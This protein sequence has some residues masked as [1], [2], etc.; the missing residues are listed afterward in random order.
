MAHHIADLMR[1]AKNVTGAERNI[2]ERQC[3][4]TIFKLWSHR[5]SFQSGRRPL[6]SFE[7]IFQML[8]KMFDERRQFY[9]SELST[10]D[11]EWLKLAEATDDVA[12]KIIRFALT[13]ASEQAS[14]QEKDWLRLAS[15]LNIQ[16]DLEVNLIKRLLQEGQSQGEE[17]Q[18]PDQGIERLKQF[19]EKLS[20]FQ[21][22]IKKLSETID[23]TLTQTKN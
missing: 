10:E 17:A 4:D 16:T 6:G 2:V 7:P 9:F 8:A 20:T 23:K 13:M 19:Q 22:I 18:Q 21:N 5:A 15:Q 1:K 11:N 3:A 14:S 12:R